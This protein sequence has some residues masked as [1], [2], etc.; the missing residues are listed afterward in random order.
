MNTMRMHRTKRALLQI[1]AWLPFAVAPHPLAFDALPPVCNPIARILAG[2]YCIP[3]WTPVNLN[4]KHSATT[5]LRPQL[6]QATMIQ[7]VIN[8]TIPYKQNRISQT[9]IKHLIMH[10]IF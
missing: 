1:F 5:T 9:I 4:S 8:P 10:K 7:I 2:G 6:I 3:Y